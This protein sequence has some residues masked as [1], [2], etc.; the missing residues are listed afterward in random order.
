MPKFL[1]LKQWQQSYTRQILVA[2]VEMTGA[3]PYLCTKQYT[4]KAEQWR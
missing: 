3:D 4:D 1:E 2:G